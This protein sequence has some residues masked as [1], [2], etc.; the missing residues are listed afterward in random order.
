MRTLLK[1]LG[2]LQVT[3]QAGTT[4]AIQLSQAVSGQRMPRITSHPP[5]TGSLPGIGRFLY[6]A[7][8]GQHT[9]LICSLVVAP[10]G[11]QAQQATCFIAYCKTLATVQ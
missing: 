11:S 4:L 3:S 9:E 6:G 1:T 10:L 5:I 8:Q 2:R 7:L